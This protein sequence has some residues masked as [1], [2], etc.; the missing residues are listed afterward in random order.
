MKQYYMNMDTT[1][2]PNNNHEVHATG[3]IW[4]PSEYN[5]VYIG[6]YSDGVQAV[7]EARRKGYYNVDGCA[8]C[9]PEAHHG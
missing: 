5:R 4:M 6:Y 8:T 1:Q 9:C 2:N 7:A 3:C